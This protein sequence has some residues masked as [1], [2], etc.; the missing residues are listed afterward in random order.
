VQQ[1]NTSCIQVLHTIIVGAEGRKSL[2]W[3]KMKYLLSQTISL[4][5]SSC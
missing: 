2:L 3:K 1:K 4:L 5:K